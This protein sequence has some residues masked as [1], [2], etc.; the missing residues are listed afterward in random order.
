MWNQFFRT[1]D[2]ELTL[3]FVEQIC[4]QAKKQ[5]QYEGNDSNTVGRRGHSECLPA[6]FIE[7]CFTVETQTLR[8]RFK[9]FRDVFLKQFPRG[10]FR[11]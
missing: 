4:P 6:Q 1:L 3:F 9:T 10:S 11:V 8:E 7:K 5:Q 2:L